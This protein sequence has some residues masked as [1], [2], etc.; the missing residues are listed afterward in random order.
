METPKS[1]VLLFKSIS[2]IGDQNDN[3]ESSKNIEKVYCELLGL[4]EII[5][6]KAKYVSDEN[7]YNYWVSSE[8]D[9]DYS[10]RVFQKE[11]GGQR[12]KGKGYDSFT[13]LD[14]WIFANQKIKAPPVKN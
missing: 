2:A 9:I 3:I 13:L 11:Q 8:L 10:E 1:P 5:G 12:V 7:A 4:A 6:E 14:L